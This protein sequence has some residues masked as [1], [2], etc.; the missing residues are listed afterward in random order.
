MLKS[1][2]AHEIK[3]ADFGLSKILSPDTLMQTACGTPIYVG[4]DVLVLFFTL[5]NCIL[6]APEVLK[7]EGYDREVDLWAVGVI[8]YIL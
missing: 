8:M 4:T 1:N 6:A 3:I 7:G 5:K 2:D